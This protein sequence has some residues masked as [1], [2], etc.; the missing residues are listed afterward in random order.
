MNMFS[1][2]GE[3]SFSTV[4]IS[5]LIIIFLYRYSIR[6]HNYW[7]ERNVPFVKPYPFI[8]T[9]LDIVTKPGHEVELER[10]LK[11][12]PIYGHFETNKPM[13][14]VGDPSIL[15]NILVKDIQVFQGNRFSETGN[16]ELDNMIT[17]AKGEN[18]KRIRT[19]ISPTFS[20]GKMKRMMGIFRDCCET[21][22]NNLAKV[23]EQ[24]ETF[25]AKRVFGA[26]TLDVIASSAFSTKLDS[27]QDPNNKFVRMA[28][29]LFSPGFNWR[30]VGVV[31][32]PKLMKLMGESFFSSESLNFFSR[33]TYQIIDERRRTGKQTAND[34]LQLLLDTC[35]EVESNGQL[36]QSFE[37]V[38][39]LTTNYGAGMEDNQAL[40]QNPVTKSLSTDEM[41]SQC[42]VFFL[43]GYESTSTTLSIACYF[44][45][46]HP[47]IQEQAYAEVKQLLQDSGV[48]YL[49]RESGK[50]Y[51]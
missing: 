31:L 21:L 48:S 1:I 35:K 22:M 7:K 26:F 51:K 27:Q 15:R 11:Y 33:V 38:D 50:K 29:K 25:D 18:W 19:I 41:V 40:L 44:M 6:S 10:Y 24:G 17:M 34:F 3:L 30:L 32:F 9:L 20:T 13:L 49:A 16:K 12:G 23:A 45:A 5:F 39:D 2:F 46:L 42:V 37:E 4:L 43:A 47:D 14:S 8:G 36:K 28:S